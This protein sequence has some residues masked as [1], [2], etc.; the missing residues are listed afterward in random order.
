MSLNLIARD[1][2]GCD[3]EYLS[4]IVT[5]NDVQAVCENWGALAGRS[6]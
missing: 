6:N 3:A 1:I 4:D 5:S 2:S